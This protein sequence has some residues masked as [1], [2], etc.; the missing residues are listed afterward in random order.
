[1]ASPDTIRLFSFQNFKTTAKTKHVFG[2]HVALR[3]KPIRVLVRG[4][5]LVDFFGNLHIAIS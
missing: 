5:H 2:I 1:M 3:E 4:F